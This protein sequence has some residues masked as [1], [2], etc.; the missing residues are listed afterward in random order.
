MKAAADQENALSVKWSLTIDT[1]R[2]EKEP[3]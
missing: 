3:V 1:C 2:G